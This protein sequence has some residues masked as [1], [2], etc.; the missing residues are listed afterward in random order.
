MQNRDKIHEEECTCDPAQG[1]GL[2]GGSRGGR[3]SV[4]EQ[5][6]ILKF[7]DAKYLPSATNQHK[8]KAQEGIYFLLS[9]TPFFQT[10]RQTSTSS[11]KP[12][13]PFHKCDSTPDPDETPAFPDQGAIRFVAKRPTK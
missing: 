10:A 7:R 6:Q 8:E 12:S 1:Y 5:I 3:G 4:Y 9:D 13:F 11:Y 2:T